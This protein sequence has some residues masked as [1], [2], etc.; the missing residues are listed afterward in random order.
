MKKLFTL[1]LFLMCC[2]VHADFW[3]GAAVG[4]AI[5]N[6]NSQN[7]TTN[8]KPSQ[9]ITD[10]NSIILGCDRFHDGACWYSKKGS[11]E[12]YSISVLQV[13]SEKAIKGWT[14]GGIVVTDSDTGN[15]SVY[16]ICNKPK[17]GV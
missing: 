3:T 10:E 4:Y 12:F 2:D 6:S 11:F 7:Q 5:G 16:I 17:D 14:Y 9:I 15:D 1:V 13:C 8:N